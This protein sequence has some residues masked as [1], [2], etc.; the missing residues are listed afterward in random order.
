[1]KKIILGS[2]LVASLLYAQGDKSADI[3]EDRIAEVSKQTAQAPKKE[4][5]KALMQKAKSL[6]KSKNPKA[7]Q[8]LYAVFKSNR[9]GY[10]IRAIPKEQGSF[11][12]RKKFPDKWCG[13]RNEEL[14]HVTG[15]KTA[16]FCHNAGFIC[17]AEQLE[18]AM[19]LAKLA[20]EYN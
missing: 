12:N 20:V 5:M 8:I 3:V 13:L 6:L 14:Q 1:M 4:N 7:E 10:T 9:S 17:V 16:T 11:K 19:K 15:V 18:D 2:L